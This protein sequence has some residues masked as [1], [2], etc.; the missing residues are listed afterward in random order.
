M[1][2]ATFLPYQLKP[3]ALSKKNACHCE[4]RRGVA[5]SRLRL[6][7]RLQFAHPGQ[8]S[9]GTLV[10]IMGVSIARVKAGVIANPEGVWQS[11]DFA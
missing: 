5:I 10:Q 11:P 2:S 3:A 8:I 9:H 7:F 4:P 6:N 1:V